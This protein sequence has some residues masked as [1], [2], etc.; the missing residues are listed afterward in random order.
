METKCQ[1][2]ADL[3]T[4]DGQLRLYIHIHIELHTHIHINIHGDKMSGE[5]RLG[6]TTD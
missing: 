5:R 6:D 4:A 2:Y 1:V 3:V